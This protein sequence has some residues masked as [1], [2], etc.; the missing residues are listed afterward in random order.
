L[1]TT[2][3]NSSSVFEKDNRLKNHWCMQ[4]TMSIVE[5][6]DQAMPMV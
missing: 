6:F 3:K 4:V 1:P 5:D 2:S